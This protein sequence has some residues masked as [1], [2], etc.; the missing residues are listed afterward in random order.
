M[1]KKEFKFIDRML[2]VGLLPQQGSFFSMKLVNDFKNE[3]AFSEEEFKNHNI[4][5]K[6][7]NY[8]WDK[9]PKEEKIVNIGPVVLSEIKKI[10]L[11]KDSNNE[12]VSEHI[13]LLEKLFDIEELFAEQ[14]KK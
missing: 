11:M 2:V 3:I 13:P 4:R 7:N 14:T 9:E 5:V 6:G 12:L 10:V 8:V 1:E